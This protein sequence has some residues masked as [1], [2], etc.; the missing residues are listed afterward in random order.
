[1]NRSTHSC[2]YVEEIGQI[3]AELLYEMIKNKK[4]L[5]KKVKLYE[6]KNSTCFR[7]SFK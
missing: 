1:M 6:K 7:L 4:N 3:R 5:K 2:R